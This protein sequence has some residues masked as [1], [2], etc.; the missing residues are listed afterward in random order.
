MMFLLRVNVLEHSPK[1]TRAHGERGIAA[2]PGK[3]AMAR[4][5]RFDPLR[6]R[7]LDLHHYLSL[8]ES[9]RQRCDNVNVISHAANADDFGTKATA[10]SGKISIHAWSH[11]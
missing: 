4:D 1:L 5:N 3:A 10:D 8:R 11:A 6:R 7:L 9:S 2:F